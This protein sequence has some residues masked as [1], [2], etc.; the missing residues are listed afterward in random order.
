MKAKGKGYLRKL[1]GRGGVMVQMALCFG[2]IFVK[3][4][5]IQDE[6]LLKECKKSHNSGH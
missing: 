5:S 6:I 4:S 3:P 1:E 2:S